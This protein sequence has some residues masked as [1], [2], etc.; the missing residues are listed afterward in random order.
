MYYAGRLEEKKIPVVSC[1]HLKWQS[2][3]TR[4]RSA[5]II[6]RL[7]FCDETKANENENKKTN[8]FA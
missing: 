5:N 8:L 4:R 3:I 1:A 7:L 2:Q 6:G